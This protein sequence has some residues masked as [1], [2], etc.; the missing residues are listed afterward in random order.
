MEPRIG[1]KTENLNA[2][3][4]LLSKILADEF[5]LYTKSRNAHWNV[6]G[7]NFYV[8]H[9]FLEKQYEQLDTIIDEVA[10]RIRMIGHYAPGTVKQFLDLT[11][12]VESIRDKNNGNGF[13]KELLADHEVIIIHLRENIIQLDV[14]FHDA[15]TSDFI[16][17]LL[18]THEQMAWMLRAHLNEKK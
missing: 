8:M 11:H 15:G 3:A 6:E 14:E 2:I 13:I 17:G 16:T 9:K 18:K 10:E 7:N 4:L 1:I 12:F 5:I